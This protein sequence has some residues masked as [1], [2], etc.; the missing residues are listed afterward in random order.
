VTRN[1]HAEV[2]AQVAGKVTENLADSRPGT[3]RSVATAPKHAVGTLTGRQRDG[4]GSALSPPAGLGASFAGD[5]DHKRRP[6]LGTKWE[7]R[8]LTAARSSSFLL[9]CARAS[10]ARIE[11]RP[12]GG[13]VDAFLGVKGSPVQIRPSRLVTKIFRIYFYPTRASKRAIYW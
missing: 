4:G 3:W 8:A 11:K 7:S 9:T 13:D 6:R 2:T 1:A 12:G 10:P 5:P